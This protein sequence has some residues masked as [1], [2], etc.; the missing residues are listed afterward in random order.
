[1]T[2]LIEFCAS[3]ISQL[4]ETVPH[5]AAAIRITAQ[6]DLTNKKTVRVLR[7]IITLASS[8]QIKV[9]TWASVPCTAG[10]PWRHVNAALG[11]ANGDAVL[12]NEFIKH[13]TKLC[14]MTKRLGGEYGWELPERCD[15]WTDPRVVDL[16]NKSGAFSVI[17]S[18]AVDWHVNRKSGVSFHRS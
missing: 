10:C 2:L 11:R 5:R 8:L 9:V 14:R 18:S 13:A 3:H 6:L 15:L 16:T 4:T 17:A 12:T 1:M 7:D